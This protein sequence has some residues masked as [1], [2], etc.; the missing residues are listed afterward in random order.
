MMCVRRIFLV[1]LLSFLLFLSFSGIAQSDSGKK[2]SFGNNW[3]LNYNLG[4]TEFY[5]DAANTGYFN[6]LSGQIAFGTGFTVRKYFSPV[7]G[8]GFN[9]LYTG[10][11]S[12]KDMVQGVAADIDLTGKYMDGNLHVIIDFNNLFWGESSRKFSFYG[13][14]GI[15]FANWASQLNDN[16]SGSSISTGDQLNGITYGNTGFVMPFSI[17]LNYMLSS[18]WQLN[19]DINLRTVLND[20][21]DVWRDGF[22]YDQPLYTSI[23]ISYLLNWR[24]HI[25]KDK[26]PKGR[27]VAPTK[28]FDPVVPLYDYNMR[29]VKE[30]SGGGGSNTQELDIVL[31]EPVREND[32]VFRVQILAKRYNL[33]EINSLKARYNISEPVFENIYNGIH[34]YSVGSFYSYKEAL[35]YAQQLKNS[36][37]SDAFVVAYKGNTRVSITPEMKR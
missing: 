16:T 2:S 1:P 27:P 6:K 8:V 7:F 17:G 36:G 21:V 14:L 20:D 35:N 26:R 37:I 28:S 29:T 24:K 32:L 34:R 22:K 15:G 31:I 11:K 23:G 33:P 3:Q 25:K 4:F 9:Y 13:T 12:H 30:D 5:G 18:N 10:L 19:F